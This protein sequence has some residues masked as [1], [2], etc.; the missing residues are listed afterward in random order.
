MAKGVFDTKPASGY[1]DHLPERYHF[2]AR[3][4]Y[5][6]VAHAVTGDWVLY[7]EPQRNRGRR[8]YIGVGRV[9]FV[10]PDP[11][12]PDHAYARRLPAFRSARR[13]LWS[14]RRGLLGIRA[15]WH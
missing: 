6:T 3:S 10:E 8:A 15:P 1:D 14:A 5:L 7:R 11:R 9:A 13:L 12:Q 4:N 2:P